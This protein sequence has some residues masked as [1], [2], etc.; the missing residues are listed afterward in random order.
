M[1]QASIHRSIDYHR[2]EHDREHRPDS[3]EL[4]FADVWEQENESEPGVNRGHGILQALMMNRGDFLGSQQARL[5]ITRRDAAVAATAIQWLGTNVGGGFL[6]KVF[7]KA[8]WELLGPRQVR[9]KERMRAE[10]NRLLTQASDLSKRASDLADRERLLGRERAEFKEQQANFLA[11]M[12][13]ANRRLF[14]RTEIVTVP[15]R[16]IRLGDE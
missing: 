3:L 1:R 10:Q 9:F 5:I 4:A 12:L 7:Q 15:R 14:Q 8:G 16:L 11:L 13:T 2:V 6:H